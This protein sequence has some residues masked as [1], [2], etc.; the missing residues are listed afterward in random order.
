MIMNDDFDVGVLEGERRLLFDHALAQ[1][2]FGCSVFWIRSLAAIGG[3]DD[4][5]GHWQI[6]R[7]GTQR[8]IVEI[9]VEA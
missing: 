5:V 1:D 4:A 2:H 6:K 7:D 3:E 9:E 8:G